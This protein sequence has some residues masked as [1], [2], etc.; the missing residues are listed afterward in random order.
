MTHFQWFVKF[1]TISETFFDEVGVNVALLA[2][3]NA[4]AAT[5]PCG[6]MVISSD[7]FREAIFEAVEDEG[8]CW[9]VA[10]PFSPTFL[11]PPL[12]MK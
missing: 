4:M 8:C 9:G 3:D 6:M 11:L 10:R 5:F 1:L 2:A 12:K 7:I